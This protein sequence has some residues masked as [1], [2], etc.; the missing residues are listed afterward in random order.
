MKPTATGLLIIHELYGKMSSSTGE[1]GA[2]QLNSQKVIPRFFGVF[3]PV[4]HSCIVQE[5]DET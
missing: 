1:E 3:V 2:N 5:L 4:L